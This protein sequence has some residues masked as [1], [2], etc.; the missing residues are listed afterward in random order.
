M[1]NSNFKKAWG[2]LS[3]IVIYLVVERCVGFLVNF[4]YLYSVLD[5]DTVW[6][7]A[8]EDQLYEQVYELQTNHIVLIAGI[9]ALICIL[10]FWPK[11]RKEWMKRPY[12]LE[13]YRPAYKKYIYAVIAS[14][15][16][17]VSANLAINAFHVFKYAYDYAE[18]SRLIYSEP[19]VLQILV[20][21][22]LMP[23]CEELLFRGLVYER[24]T[25]YSGERAGMI[26]TSLLF[27]FFHGT[28]IQIIYAFVFSMVM[29]Y[30]YK[31]TGSFGTP[32]LFHIASNL[33]A[34]VFRQLPVF[35][36]LGFSIGIVAFALIGLSGLYLLK[37][38]DF[39]RMVRL[40]VS[41]TG[42]G[43]AD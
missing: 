13:M 29:I 9:V 39:F 43:K 8:L 37:Q 30:A 33:S 26:L 1:G 36:T 10:I 2:I 34:L 24:I 16:L 40:D 25:N 32:V 38:G 22:I 18:V 20:I 4:I 5:E 23:V 28:W 11:L 12:R 21:G 31:R 17:T 15:G 41:D 3:P 14:V 35:S 6:T 19:V 7:D 27:G 42:T